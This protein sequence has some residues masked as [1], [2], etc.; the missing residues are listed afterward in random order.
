MPRT[1]QKTMTSTVTMQ[2]TAAESN[3]PIINSKANDN[4]VSDST[5]NEWHTV[6]IGMPV[7]LLLVTVLIAGGIWYKR[8]RRYTSV[9][10][11]PTSDESSNLEQERHEPGEDDEQ[12]VIAK[13]IRK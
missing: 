13:G 10:R 9:H 1:V 5:A 11:N 4:S 12:N 7:F 3:N 8:E 2:P 6:G